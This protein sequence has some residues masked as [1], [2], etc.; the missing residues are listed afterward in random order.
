MP[1]T[2]YNSPG[3]SFLQGLSFQTPPRNFTLAPQQY[4]PRPTY[5]IQPLTS[6]GLTNTATGKPVIQP[7]LNTTPQNITPP[8][9]TTVPTGTQSVKPSSSGK[10]LGS[11]TTQS[12]INQNSGIGEG[13]S[14]P[15]ARAAEI[16]RVLSSRNQES[17]LVNDTYNSA[18]QEIQAA[19]QRANEYLGQGTNQI[20]QSFDAQRGIF[21]TAQNQLLG[22]LGTQGQ[23][24]QQQGANALSNA[25][26]LFNE[27]ST[28]TRQRYG[29]GTS[30]GEFASNLTGREFQKQQGG[31]Q[32]TTAQNI[33]AIET[34]KQSVREN[35]ANQVS[36]LEAQK[37]QALLQ[38]KDQFNQQLNQLSSMRMQSQEAKNNALRDMLT[39]Y[40]ARAQALF[41]NA[42]QIKN[43]LIANTISGIQQIAANEQAT[44][45]Q[46]GKPVDVNAFPGYQSNTIAPLASQY[47]SGG[48][49]LSGILGNKKLF[50][51]NIFSP[52]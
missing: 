38:I 15:D 43:S 22:D 40:R 17:N 51:Q 33:Q 52:A 20:N 47:T 18:L 35:Y 12:I 11:S 39:E 50:E 10:V 41:D 34:R 48:L 26:S 28:G 37:G 21:D 27:L 7:T 9:G 23:N 8:K 46:L 14:D 2:Q 1:F 16:Q 5:G 4:L 36:Q 45:T 49:P 29:A 42:E 24:T 13:I 3:L 30:A 19:E 44:R 32:Q 31:I 25:R 6:T